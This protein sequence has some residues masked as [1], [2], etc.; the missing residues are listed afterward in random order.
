ME[1]LVRNPELAEQLGSAGRARVVAEFSRDA[2]GRRLDGLVHE[3][4]VIG[5]TPATGVARLRTR[6]WWSGLG[7]FVLVLAALMSV[8]VPSLLGA[9]ALGLVGAPGGVGEAG[10]GTSWGMGD[11]ARVISGLDRGSASTAQD[12]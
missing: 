8:I 6:R 3:L 10:A 1:G 12:L 2:L 11:D 9:F 4:A 7:C 5:S